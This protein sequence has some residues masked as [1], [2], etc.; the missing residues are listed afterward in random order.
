[1]KKWFAALLFASIVLVPVAAKA[2]EIKV[3]TKG[4][5]ST[6]T[7]PPGWIILSIQRHSLPLNLDVPGFFSP[8]A[9]HTT[10]VVNETTEWLSNQYTIAF[11]TPDYD[12]VETLT[13][14]G[15][16]KKFVYYSPYS[17]QKLK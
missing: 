12:T 3:E 10:K 6:I 5:V 16:K 7:I 11:R 8:T 14:P 1:M 2:N 13:I 9:R 4:D 17:P 15:P